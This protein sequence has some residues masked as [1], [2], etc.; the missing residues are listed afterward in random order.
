M[1][2]ILH[3]LLELDTHSLGDDGDDK[4]ETVMECLIR[5]PQTTVLSPPVVELFYHLSITDN[6][7][8]MTQ[9]FI[10]QCVC[11]CL[12]SPS[13]TYFCEL[14]LI[15]IVPCLFTKYKFCCFTDCCCFY[16]C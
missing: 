12:L 8:R 7:I 14:G 1:R 11:D 10:I 3:L 9:R 15:L 16:S 2:Q 5:L 13:L 6:T 4:R